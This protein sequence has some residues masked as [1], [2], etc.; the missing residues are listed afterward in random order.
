L[1]LETTWL[2]RY[3]AGL[4]GAAKTYRTRRARVLIA[5]PDSAL[6]A[7]ERCNVAETIE[8]IVAETSESRGEPS[9]IRAMA[10]AG[11]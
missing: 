5:T 9:A 10:H 8:A 2:D 6:H 11:A 7:F 4:I 1:L 3:A